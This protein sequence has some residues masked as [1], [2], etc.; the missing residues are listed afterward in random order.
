MY[1]QLLFLIVFCLFFTTVLSLRCYGG[2]D[3]QC[4][5]TS[6]KNKCYS[7]TTCY[8]AKYRFQ[9]TPSDQ[10]CSEYEQ[11]NY[12]RKWAYGIVSDNACELLKKSRI[13]ED[14]ICCS[15]DGCNRPDS[16]K[17]SLSHYR[18]KSMRKLTDLIDV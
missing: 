16:G 8:C 18:R 1:R 6:D 14:A 4:M 15:T 17:C 13:Y 3:R 12:V 5:L 9:C 7:N 11:K 10:N 2:T